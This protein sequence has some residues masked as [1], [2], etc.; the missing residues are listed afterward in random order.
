MYLLFGSILEELTDKIKDILD[1]CSY[2]F[3][4]VGTEEGKQMADMYGVDA[5]PYLIYFKEDFSASI[6]ILN[7]YIYHENAT[8]NRYFNEANGI[9]T[10]RVDVD[11]FLKDTKEFVLK[12][13]IE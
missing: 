13:G 12:H 1:K 11:R 4:D 9:S 5:T 8:L 7:Y 6:S 2:D 3:V 10:E